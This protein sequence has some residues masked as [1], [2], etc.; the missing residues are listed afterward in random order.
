MSAN[1]HCLLSPITMYYRSPFLFFSP[2]CFPF[3]LLLFPDCSTQPIYF[4]HLWL[5]VYL[6]Y[7]IDQ[8]FPYPRPPI[9]VSFPFQLYLFLGGMLGFL[10]PLAS[11]YAL[12]FGK[13]ISFIHL[14]FPSFK[15]QVLK[16]SITTRH[17]PSV[18]TTKKMSFQHILSQVKAQVLNF[19]PSQGNSSLHFKSNAQVLLLM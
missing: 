4:F 5:I 9:P 16:L 7:K 18:I 12:L 19:W 3:S 15:Q 17:I 6:I 1:N 14:T 2:V 11:F 13:R 8:F 10:F